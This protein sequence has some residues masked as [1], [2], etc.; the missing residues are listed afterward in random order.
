MHYIIIHWNQSGPFKSLNYIIWRIIMG[1]SSTVDFRNNCSLSSLVTT[2]FSSCQIIS[3]F[4]A[5]LF[6]KLLLPYLI[7]KLKINSSWTLKKITR[8]RVISSLL[9]C[10]FIKFFKTVTAGTA[11]MCDFRQATYSLCF[12]KLT[13]KQKGWPGR[14]LFF[15]F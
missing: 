3:A 2:L 6:R 15:F 8:S 12:S 1:R 9:L 11:T 4:Y 13:R 14:P 5:L 10:N 7:W